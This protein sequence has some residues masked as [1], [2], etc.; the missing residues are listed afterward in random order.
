MESNVEN[1]NLSPEDV[2]Q[3]WNEEAAKLDADDNSSAPELLADVPDE[4]PPQ[5]Q[6]EDA[7]AAQQATEPEPEPDPLAG[8]SDGV[9]AKLAEIDELKQANAHLLHHV[10]TTEG[11]VAAMQR[12][13][14]QARRAQQTVGDNV[15]PSQGQIA[16]AAKNPEKWDQLKQDF[17]E[18][19]DAVEEFVNSR[20]G[21]SQ[22]QNGLTP[23]NIANFVQ[24]KVAETRAEMTKLLE[25]A[26]IEGKY[27][28]WK[29]IV[30][31]PDFAQWYAVQ[32]PQIRA[33]ADSTSSKD[34]LKMLD[35]FHETKK[36]SAADI[37]QER[38]QRLAAAATTKPGNT[39]P[40]KTLDDMSPEELWNYEA[41]KREKTKA[42]RGF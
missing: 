2:E 31:T 33:L 29:G 19:G 8:L 36:R 20:L 13:A 10:K 32:N 9:R 23:E 22:Q 4:N 40:P 1:E 37:K 39:P 15:A 41:A 12:E 11:R 7:E 16:A 28:D 42:Q 5:I 3:I 35:L 21:N 26:R 17:P 25:E 34:A 6:E 24:A 18:W 38:E 14:E 27:E 30:N